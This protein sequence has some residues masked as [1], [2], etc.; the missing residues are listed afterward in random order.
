MK[1][2]KQ[3]FAGVLF[4]FI[5]LN[6]AYGFSGPDP[7]DK[8]REAIESS[9]VFKGYISPGLASRRTEQIKE[10]EE[11]FPGFRLI[12]NH[13]ACESCEDEDSRSIIKKGD[14][15]LDRFRFL[16]DCAAKGGCWYS[17]RNCIDYAYITAI[18][19]NCP[20][21]DAAVAIID[22]L[23]REGVY[24]KV[25]N[26]IETQEVDDPEE[27]V[28]VIYSNNNGPTHFGIYRGDGIVESKWGGINAIFQHKVFQ[29]M[30]SYGDEV[31]F[32]KVV[33]KELPPHFVKENWPNPLWELGS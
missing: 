23:M 21:Q 14:A 2:F 28:L 10:F 7:E 20:D 30:P 17:R 12:N 32:Q 27:A 4:V 16:K 24:I 6:T 29:V 1:F 3:F 15:P 9:H 22:Y 25:F 5:I 31:L 18:F 13:L 33:F 8:F 26:F 19:E 11:D